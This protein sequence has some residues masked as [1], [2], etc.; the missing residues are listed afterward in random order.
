M[1][2]KT[3]LAAI[4]LAGACTAAVLLVGCEEGSGTRGLNI[5]PSVVELGKTENEETEGTNGTTTT[6]TTL[7]E[8]TVVFSVVSNDLRALSFPLEW[9][10]TNPDLG[11]ITSA[12]GASAVYVRTWAGGVNVVGVRDQYGEEGYATVY[13]D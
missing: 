8:T 1:N 13:Q 9:W 3:A 12:S 4:W 6:E 10:V 5:T 2:E 7:D 11:L